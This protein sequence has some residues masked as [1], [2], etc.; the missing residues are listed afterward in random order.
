MTHLLID[1]IEASINKEIRLK[2]TKLKLFYGKNERRIKR[3]V[4]FIK[5]LKN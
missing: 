3:I 1:H 5:T 2:I 4:K